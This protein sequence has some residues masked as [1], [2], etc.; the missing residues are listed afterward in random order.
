MHDARCLKIERLLRSTIVSYQSTI[1]IPQI[2]ISQLH[3]SSLVAYWLLFLRGTWF[4]SQWGRKIWLFCFWVVIS[5]LLFT[6]ELVHDYAKWSIHELIWNN[7]IT[8]MSKKYV[9]SSNNI[10]KLLFMHS[11]VLLKDLFKAQYIYLFCKLFLF[12]IW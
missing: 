10:I 1:A 2:A 8:N 11:I 7:Q 9:G 5:W 12:T 6:L 4:K 3:C